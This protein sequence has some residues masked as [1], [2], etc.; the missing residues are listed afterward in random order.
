MRLESENLK[1][2][3]E[4][5]QLTEIKNQVLPMT[6]NILAT[7]KK[8]N[9][10]RE[11]KITT[12]E[13]D[14]TIM[15]NQ[16]AVKNEV[17]KELK[18]KNEKLNQENENIK[19]QIQVVKN[20]YKQ[21]IDEFSQKNQQNKAKIEDLNSIISKVFDQLKQSDCKEI[22]K[23][24]KQLK[25]IIQKL[26]EK[27]KTQKEQIQTRDLIIF[28]NFNNLKI[29]D[30]ILTNSL[31]KF[32][33]PSTISKIEKENYEAILSELNE[34][35]VSLLEKESSDL[36]FNTARLYFLYNYVPF[37]PKEQQNK[38]MEEVVPHYFELIAD[39]LKSDESEDKK[40][41]ESAFKYLRTFIITK[42]SK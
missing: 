7:L 10:E 29:P 42:S 26:N 21:K 41:D 30:E 17:E 34:Y 11:A 4:N 39:Q 13:T 1:L 15:R 28:S 24:N 2:K 31:S 40:N 22:L 9:E 8:Q 27:V 35:Y 36:I 5:L 16:L 32:A 38:L 12:L 37:L 6:K 18:K 20:K 19:S 25:T 33:I 23:E 3:K 14:F